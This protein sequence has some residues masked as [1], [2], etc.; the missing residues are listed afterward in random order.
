[1][2]EMF[3]V[4]GYPYMARPVMVYKEIEYF[5]NYFVITNFNGK[6]KIIWEK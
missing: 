5:S 6:T 4:D 2:E 3:D 1:M